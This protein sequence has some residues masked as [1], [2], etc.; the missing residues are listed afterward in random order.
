M[1]ENPSHVAYRDFTCPD[2]YVSTKVPLRQIQFMDPIAVHARI[3]AEAERYAGFCESV[4]HGR[5]AYG[6]PVIYRTPKGRM[7]ASDIRYSDIILY[8]EQ[9]VRT[10]A[11]VPRNPIHPMMPVKIIEVSS[12]DDIPVQR[13][14]YLEA[15][16]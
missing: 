5:Y 1:D 9:T 13:A 4:R 11:S 8:A 16:Q 15:Q 10:H 7:F 12:R 3:V 6:V 2:G 14:A